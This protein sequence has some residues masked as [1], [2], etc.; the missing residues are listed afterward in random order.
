MLG[1]SS[2]SDM[3]DRILE[4]LLSLDNMCDQIYYMILFLLTHMTGDVTG[5]T[6]F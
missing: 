1:D 4:Y 2:Y 3:D 6:F 5:H